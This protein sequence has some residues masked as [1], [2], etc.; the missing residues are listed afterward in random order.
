MKKYYSILG[1]DENANVEDI[2]KSYK[3][4]AVKFHP[5]KNQNNKEEAEEKFKEITEAYD[6]LSDP[7][8]KQMYDSLGDLQFQQA[9]QGGGGGAHFTDPMDMFSKIFGFKMG[10]GMNGVDEFDEESEN[11]FSFIFGNGMGGQ[12]GFPGNRR[13]GN[14][15]EDIILRKEV[16]LKQLYTNEVIQIDFQRQTYC[17]DCS[18]SGSKNGKKGICKS[19]NGSGRMKIVHQ[20]GMMLQQVITECNQCNGSGKFIDKGNECLSCIGTGMINEK[21]NTTFKLDK[22]M[23]FEKN[24]KLPI[25]GHKN[26]KGKSGRVFLILQVNPKYKNFELRGSHLFTKIEIS[27]ADALGGFTHTTEF[28]DDQKISLTRN[29]VSQPGSL[30]K[31]PK[32]G[33]DNNSFLIVLV[34]VI[35][36]EFL[37]RNL[38]Q[39]IKDTYNKQ[40]PEIVLNRNYNIDQV[41]SEEI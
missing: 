19:C 29:Q 41:Y 38:L 36:P 14:D 3:K 9:T 40:E 21:V 22:K 24:I 18:S 26:I 11:P 15:M 39:S 5:D 10:G 27:L 1:L 35:L 6:V 28:I 25:H 30:W 33:F 7:K 12:P 4:L 2:K 37:P 32:L 20:M 8:K 17:I 34:N 31:I 23:I 16:N 13:N